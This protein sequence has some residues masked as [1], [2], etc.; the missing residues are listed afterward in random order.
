MGPGEKRA[1]FVRTPC[2]RVRLV[3]PRMLLVDPG[4]AEWSQILDNIKV[5][6]RKGYDVRASR[7][8]LFGPKRTLT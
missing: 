6:R 5:Y 7:R 1:V 4:V 2:S 8:A 3:G